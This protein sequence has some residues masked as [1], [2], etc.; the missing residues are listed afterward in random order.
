MSFL[1]CFER[2]PLILNFYLPLHTIRRYVF[3]K[4]LKSSLYANCFGF[5]FCCSKS[6]C[7]AFRL[8]FGLSLSGGKAAR[9]ITLLLP[10]Y[11]FTFYILHFTFY[12]FPALIGA[13]APPTS[14]A[15]EQSISSLHSHYYWSRL[16]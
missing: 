11:H 13:P 3:D 6:F 7:G 4:K 2:F 12:Q 10:F 8:A 5:N 14:K 1:Y 15:P 9:A 16:E